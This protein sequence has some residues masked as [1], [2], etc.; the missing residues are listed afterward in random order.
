LKLVS[1]KVVEENVANVMIQY[2]EL[3]DLSEFESNS[4]D[5]VISC[6]GLQNAKAPSHLIN[7]IHRVLKPGGRVIAAV[8]EHS[9]TKPIVDRILAKVKCTKKMEM[10]T[11][12]LTVPHLL[13][14][15][16]EKSG[17][18]VL[19]IQHGEYPI[20]LSTAGG[21]HASAFDI[22]SLPIKRDL[23]ELMNTGER[24]YAFE[25]AR[26]E[27]DNI[28][29]Q[30]NLVTT[31]S[32]GRLVVE[33]NRYKII[34]ARRQYE[35]NDRRREIEKA[36]ES[37]NI[38]SSTLGLAK[39][40]AD[41]ADR[42]KRDFNQLLI[43]TLHG[44]VPNSPW[45]CVVEAVKR[46]ILASGHN[47]SK[48]PKVLDLASFPNHTTKLMAEELPSVHIHSFNMSAE[49]VNDMKKYAS[50]H[51]LNHITSSQM[52][53]MQLKDFEDASMD[54]VTCAFGLTQ[55]TDPT[56]ILQE[57]HRVLK[58]GGSFIATAWDSIALERIGDAILSEVLSD[59]D[60]HIITPIS[61]LSSY[62]TP[63]KFEQLIESAG[64][65]SILK[66][67]HYESPFQL[68]DEDNVTSEKKLSAAFQNAIIPIHHL[69]KSLEESGVNPN[70]FDDAR[71]IYN[72]L[73]EENQLMW[74]DDEGKIRT[75]SNRFQFIIARRKF[76]DADGILDKETFVH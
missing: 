38:P 26:A 42:M 46:D 59:T 45:K 66:S 24:P 65:L 22:V 40:D 30:G 9:G 50:V 16:I 37:K 28:V 8:W 4:F 70:A 12:R 35:D 68:G 48:I 76:E 71:R 72:R 2:N 6:Y 5:L 56:Q 52:S 60:P 62:S 54:V 13:E 7:E 27:F 58:P 15:I 21:L 44:D 20:Y 61:N 64:N 63:R 32:Q 55:F 11:D 3:D 31:D 41:I 49:G 39:A 75:V 1:D 74:K 29:S 23:V 19:E 69:L 67:D 51:K 43:D 17:L 53:G 33:D 10:E 47:G 34:V 73:L 18:K 57:I 25:D 14:T 36:K